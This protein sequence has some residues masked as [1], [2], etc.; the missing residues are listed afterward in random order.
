[1]KLLLTVICGLILAVLTGV[2]ATRSSGVLIMTF[3]DWTLQ[4]STNFFLLACG[5]IFIVLYFSIR[6]VVRLIRLP[7]QYSSYRDKKNLIRSDHY[8]ANG[9]MAMIEG[10]WHGAERAF[11][12]GTRFSR[13]PQLNYIGAARAAQKQ[14][15]L[16]RRDEYLRL[17][18]HHAPGKSP[19]AG[20]AQ[21]QL[22]IEQH[23]SE[24]ALAVLN[25]LRSRYPKQL[26]VKYLL[27]DLYT[28]MEEWRPVIELLR[29]MK[30]IKQTDPDRIRS[31]QLQAYA[32]LLK[33]AGDS[34]DDKVLARTWISIPKKFRRELYLIEAYV[35]QRIR[36]PDHFDAEIQIRNILKTRW[37]ETLVR[38]YGFVRGHDP[39]Q[40]LDFAED[41]LRK[42]AR[43]PVL[44]ITLGRLCLQNK[45]WGKARMYFEE[46]LSIKPSPELY[47]ELAALLERLGEKEGAAGCYQKGLQMATDTGSMRLLE[48]NDL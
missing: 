2:F 37:D 14:G 38:L 12:K 31:Q 48:S 13:S 35:V 3:G 24:Q 29:E 9:M 25:D 33:Q 5:F 44:L 42:R 7:R 39:M 19:A 30:S 22:F 21:A 11:D 28:R 45:L 41:L 32:G 8:L 17:A 43:D 26:E 23:Q 46:C 1:M 4:T 36:F 16:D 18:H 40:Q 27:L 10:D 47:R 15:Q 6:L 34:G 20:I